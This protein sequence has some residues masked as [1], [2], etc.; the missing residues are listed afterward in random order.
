MAFSARECQ[1]I[2][3]DNNDGDDADDDGDDEKIRLLNSQ[4]S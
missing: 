3:D 4:C 1:A 2:S